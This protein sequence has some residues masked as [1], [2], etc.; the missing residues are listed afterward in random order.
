MTISSPV[1]KTWYKSRACQLLLA[2]TDAGRLMF[3]WE[4][5]LSDGGIIRQF[6]DHTWELLMSNSLMFPPTDLKLSTDIIP[7][8]KVIQ[9]TL[10]PTAL[11]KASCPWFNQ[12]GLCF[13]QFVDPLKEELLAYWLVDHHILGGPGTPHIVRQVL[14]VRNRET[15]ER[16]LTVICPSGI[17]VES[18]PNDDQSYE[19][20]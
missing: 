16:K 4:A 15:H 17:V 18:L 20:E 19:G 14:G 3:I 11:T 12:E 13:N 7:R 10:F 9:F 2:S 1:D 8:D 6:E 5:R